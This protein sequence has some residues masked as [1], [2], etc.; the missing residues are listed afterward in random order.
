[1]SITVDYPNELQREGQ[2]RD[3]IVVCEDAD[4]DGV[5]DRVTTFADKLS[6][7]TSILP[8]AG[9]VIVHQAPVTLFLKDTD[10]DDKADE[11]GA[12]QR[13]GT[14]IRTPGRATSPGASQL[15]LRI[16]GYAAAGPPARAVPFRTGFPPT[17][18]RTVED[19]KFCEHQQ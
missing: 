10:G 16:V 9:G 6:I 3:R 14:A 13:L 12:L 15:A 18:G 2:G 11:T 4:G 17:P 1:V 19:R 8:Y 7:A 5:C